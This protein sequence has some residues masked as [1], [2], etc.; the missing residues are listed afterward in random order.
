MSE[1]FWGE[2]AARP[3]LEAIVANG[4]AQRLPPACFFKSGEKK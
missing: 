3:A 1:R 2:G 4:G